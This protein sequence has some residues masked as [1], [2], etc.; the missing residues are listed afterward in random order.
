MCSQR[1]AAH[2]EAPRL[3]RATQGKT[4][5]KNSYTITK[6]FRIHIP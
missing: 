2:L 4:V 5:F 3:K 1:E 6:H